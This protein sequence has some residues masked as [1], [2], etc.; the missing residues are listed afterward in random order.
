MKYPFVLTCTLL[1]SILAFSQKIKLTLGPILDHKERL[2][3]AG[4]PL[5]VYTSSPD[6][7]DT[8]SNK[9]INFFGFA[10]RNPWL[11]LNDDYVKLWY[12]KP[13]SAELIVEGDKETFKRI[14][15]VAINKKLFILYSIDFPS[16]D[17][18]SVYANE[19]S[20]DYTA[21]GSPI[22]IHKYIGLKKDGNSVSLG[23]SRNNQY[24]LLF[25]DIETKPREPRKFECK[26]VD[27][28]FAEVWSR[29][30]E[31]ENKD[32]ERT[33]LR[34][35]IDNSGD[36]FIVSQKEKKPESG[37]LLHFY[38]WKEK[39]FETVVLGPTEGDNFGVR[40]EII[41]GV[42]PY[43]IGLNQQKKSVSCFVDRFDV[44]STT[45]QHLSNTPMPEDFYKASNFNRFE[46]K[47]W[48]IDD[49]VSLE[50]HSLVASIEARL[51]VTVNGVTGGYYTYHTFINAF[52]ENGSLKYQHAV[53][54][55]QGAAN[56]FI[57]LSLIPYKNTILAVYNDHPDNFELSPSDKKTK[58]YSGGESMTMVQQI[59]EAGKVSKYQLTTDPTMKNWSINI[60]ALVRVKRRLFFST[61]LMRK[62]LISR[63]LRALTFEIE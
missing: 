46:T 42:K 21:F 37:P 43:I 45:L 39:V 40:L 28:S 4:I 34:T 44:A 32:K 63:D 19:V 53:R 27:A 41:D 36:I 48:G 14:S 15:F 5:S 52:S 20:K 3:L 10:G 9:T 60:D 25:R 59:D 35:D 22:L 11:V 31:V 7:F 54:K 47:H 6:V 61:A 18:F 2:K 29:A 23:L 51:V 12:T 8:L 13:L 16:A 33:I 57:G 58:F 56:E 24:L 17:Q 55:I 26:V 30:F 1:I 49:I 38:K 62:G 50:N